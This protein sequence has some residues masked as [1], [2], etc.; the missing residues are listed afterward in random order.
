MGPPPALEALEP[1]GGRSEAGSSTG[2]DRCQKR[3]VPARDCRAL[4]A[5]RTLVC[6]EIEV[7]EQKLM[8][9]LWGLS[10]RPPRG[11]ESR[12]RSAGRCWRVGAGEGRVALDIGV[13]GCHCRCWAM[14]DQA[15][16]PQP[17]FPIPFSLLRF[18][19]LALS[20]SNSVVWALWLL[21]V[22]SPCL[23]S[24]SSAWDY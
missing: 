18:S 24:Y 9:T 15:D 6:S 3:R 13:V 11:L 7:E 23:Q 1:R 4:T 14:R 22:S 17:T 21:L 12:L 2:F 10:Q 5:K 8:P 16:T 19:P 20:R